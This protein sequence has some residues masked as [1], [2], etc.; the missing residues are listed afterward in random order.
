MARQGISQPPVKPTLSYLALEP[1]IELNF[2]ATRQYYLGV[3]GVRA[4]DD[5][6]KCLVFTHLSWRDVSRSGFV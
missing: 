6:V 5:D 4:S 1:K 2:L 3:P